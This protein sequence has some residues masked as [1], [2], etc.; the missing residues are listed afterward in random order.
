MSEREVGTRPTSTSMAFVLRTMDSS[1]SGTSARAA[2]R[3][4]LAELT[5]PAEVSSTPKTKAVLCDGKAC[6]AAVD[7]PLCRTYLPPVEGR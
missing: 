2:A 6:Y 7:D 5:V 1:R 3:F 4:S